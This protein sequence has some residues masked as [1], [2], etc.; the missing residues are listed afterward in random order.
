[1]YCK[2]YIFYHIFAAERYKQ[3]KIFEY[4]EDANKQSAMPNLFG[5]CRT[6]VF[7][8]MSKIWKSGS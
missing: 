2:V 4:N 7:K 6:E 1:M 3:Q 8:I 5:L